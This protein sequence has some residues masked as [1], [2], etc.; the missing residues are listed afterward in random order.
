MV[1][2]HQSYSQLCRQV[3]KCHEGHAPPRIIHVKMFDV[4]CNLALQT[5]GCT[6]VQ[7][8]VIDNGLRC[9]LRGYYR[10]DESWLGQYHKRCIISPNKIEQNTSGVPT[11][12]YDAVN[13]TRILKWCECHFS[14]ACCNLYSERFAANRIAAQ[15]A[16]ISEQA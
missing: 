4:P 9:V 15:W 13:V 2:R 6:S 8:K 1:C 14:R 5:M 16:R 11:S 10:V 12:V 7:S 3:K